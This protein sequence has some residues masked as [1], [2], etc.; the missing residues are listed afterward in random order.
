[1]S[2]NLEGYFP[3]PFT[4][5]AIN[6]KLGTDVFIIIDGRPVRFGA[7]GE[8]FDEERSLRLKKF[9]FGKVF[10]RQEEQSLYRAY[11]DESILLM[12]KQPE[13]TRL[14]TQM[15]TG[16]AEEA[17]ERVL[18]N[19]S[20]K[21]VYSDAQIQFDRFAKFLQ[22]HKGS[23]TE[24]FKRSGINPID[25]VS[26]GVQVAALTVLLCENLK[27]IRDEQHRKLITTACFLHDIGAEKANLPILFDKNT[28]NPE[29]KKKWT[30]HPS[31]AIEMLGSLNHIEQQVLTI[32]FQHEEI[33][34]GSGIPKGLQRKDMDPIACV[35]SMANRFDHYS[36]QFKGDKKVAMAEFFKGELGKFELDQLE[37]LKKIVQENS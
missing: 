13:S 1:M 12:E 33:P 11:V 26:H 17:A 14:Q 36:A 20:D 32:I 25:Y 35:V 2:Q 10:V 22:N 37:L 4:T 24:V 6:Q 18:E 30:A 29:Q 5:L 8:V 3:V 7:K 15:I 21:T 27:L 19:V 34:N 16:V 9:N 23:F 28:F 31:A